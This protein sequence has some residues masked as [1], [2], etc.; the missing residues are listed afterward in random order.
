MPK[1][2]LIED[3][4]MLRDSLKH[5]MLN[6]GYEV[7]ALE[8]VEDLFDHALDYWDLAILDVGLPGEDG[9][10]FASRLRKARP[11]MI[12]IVLSVN[13]HSENRVACYESDADLFLAKPLDSEE[14]LAAMAAY[15]RKKKRRQ[16]TA[17]MV[18][19]LEANLLTYHNHYVRLTANETR[20]LHAMLMA[21]ADLVEVWQLKAALGFIDDDGKNRLEVLISRLRKKLFQA[22]DLGDLIQAERGQGYKLS[23]A[24]VA[25]D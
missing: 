5:L 19:N 18:L 13:D 22:F 23:Q 3:H 14:L 2:L 6:Q 25:E 4:K 12:I 20:L 1:V 17:P 21:E 8:S 24:I 10:S 9:L 11:D 16:D 7:T 15:L